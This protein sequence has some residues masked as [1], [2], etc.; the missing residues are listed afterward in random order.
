MNDMVTYQNNMNKLNFKG[1]TQMDMNI[2]MALCSQMK[3][4]D[5]AEV[6]LTFSQI[7]NLTNYEK[8]NSTKEF[9]ADLRRMNEHLMSVNCEIITRTEI[10]M[11]VLFPTFKINPDEE[12]LTVAVNK[13]FTWLLNE[14][15]SYTSFELAE[16]INL[17]SKYSKNLYR[18]LKQ[19]RTKGQYTFHDLEEFRNLMD[20]P[21]SYTNKYMMNECV[22]VA[23]KEISELDK[24]FKDFKCEPQYAR[25]RG[26]PLE[27]LIF[28]WQ[29]E[30]AELAE[31]EQLEG[32]E[33]FSDAQSFEDYIKSYQ[34]ED[35]PSPVAMKIAKD[36]EKGR[37]KAK[38]EPK[39]NAFNNFEQRNYSDRYYELLEKQ[40]TTGLTAEEE[41]EF[42]EETAKCNNKKEV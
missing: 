12:I 29:P 6:V 25:K 3:E 13:D 37:K 40:S 17:K 30:V 22:I 7:K 16:F 9:I 32:Q 31:D 8:K 41:M 38:T 27:K 15:K 23:V 10:I 11:F 4:R 36:I 35:K 28:T 26:K 42:A 14:M 2:F 21:L 20:I 39:K 34:G 1:F 5:V 18:L 19:W 24:S 33:G